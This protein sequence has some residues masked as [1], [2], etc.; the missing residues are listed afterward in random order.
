MPPP[1]PSLVPDPSNNNIT[2]FYGPFPSVPD[3]GICLLLTRDWSLPVQAGAVLAAG[4]P[5]ARAGRVLQAA[6]QDAQ[7]PAARGREP[8]ALPR[9]VRQPRAQLRHPRAGGA[10][11]AGGARD[12][13]VRAV[14]LPDPPAAHPQ[15]DHRVHRPPRREDGQGA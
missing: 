13:G 8:E 10:S 6:E 12:A 5:L 4:V 3:P 2:S 1:C 11:E 9:D 14:P 15:D 7:A